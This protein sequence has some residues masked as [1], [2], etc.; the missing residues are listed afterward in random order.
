M[1]PLQKQ[2]L[3]WKILSGSDCAASFVS[4]PSFESITLF[5]SRCQPR[6]FIYIVNTSFPLQESSYCIRL[7]GSKQTDARTTHTVDGRYNRVDVHLE[8]FLSLSW[9]CSWILS[10]FVCV[11]SFF[12][13]D[14]TGGGEPPTFTVRKTERKSLN[15]Y[16]Y[17]TRFPQGTH[18]DK[19][20]MIRAL[21]PPLDSTLE[22]VPFFRPWR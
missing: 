20:T 18:V 8:S 16:R 19:S 10:L 4:W 11:Y 17:R 9:L 7:L 3:D 5:S 21:I 14:R 22:P 1:L 6:Y 13:F 12:C 2:E 15:S